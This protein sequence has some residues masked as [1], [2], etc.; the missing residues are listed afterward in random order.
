[1]VGSA[2]ESKTRAAASGSAKTLNSAAAVE[3]PGPVPPPIRERPAMRRGHDGSRSMARAMLVSGPRATTH[4]SSAAASRRKVTASPLAGVRSCSKGPAPPRPV[5]PWTSVAWTASP[6]RGREAPAWTGVPA[7]KRAVTRRALA[8]VAARGALPL[9][10]VT[11]ITSAWRWARIRAAASSRP[12]S[13]SINILCVIGIRRPF[14]CTRKMLLSAPGGGGEVVGPDRSSRKGL[15]RESAAPVL[16]WPADPGVREGP[17]GASVPVRAR[18]RPAISASS[19][20]G[21]T[22]PAGRARHLDTASS[23][24]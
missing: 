6:A 5:S 18:R 23:P 2:P 7:L 8:V 3:L 17:G 4:T 9:T 16:G 10:V 24:R 1:M 21:S 19:Q 15:V 12:G 20:T 22:I 11:P 14:G 13:Q